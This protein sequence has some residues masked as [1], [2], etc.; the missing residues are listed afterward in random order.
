M[1]RR[2]AIDAGGGVQPSIEEFSIARQVIKKSRLV[3]ALE[4]HV[5]SEVGRPRHL[6]LEGLLVAMQINA[7]RRLHRAHIVQAARTLNAMTT[8]ERD[9]LGI[10]N[11]DA[12]EAY[13]R[14]D[15]LF[16]KLTACSTR[17]RQV[18]T[19]PGSRTALAS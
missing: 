17:A 1:T 13:P 5:G 4:A 7:L 18:S 8:D 19:P 6:S 3:A 14:V 10:R 12:A 11:W 2:S 15:W 16:C 9:A